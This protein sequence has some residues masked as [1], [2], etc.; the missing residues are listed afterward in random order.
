ME[1]QPQYP[2][3]PYTQ[4]CDENGHEVDPY[5]KPGDPVSFCQCAKGT[6]KY[7]E[8]IGTSHE[9]AI[10][11]AAIHVALEIRQYGFDGHDAAFDDFQDKFINSGWS[12]D[13]QEYAAWVQD[14][15]P[16]VQWA[17][18]FASLRQYL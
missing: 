13:E 10:K 2:S 14:N 7:M 17:L 1:H 12:N 16:A 8:S 11:V 18:D 5:A 9:V 4:K 6:A 3:C 15:D